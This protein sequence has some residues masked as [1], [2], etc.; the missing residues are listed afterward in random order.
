MNI[1]SV[2][3]QIS[4]QV[5]HGRPVAARP[6]ERVA[7]RELMIEFDPEP[8]PEVAAAFS[9]FCRVTDTRARLGSYNVHA[10]TEDN[11]TRAQ[12]T[13]TVNV[14]DVARVGRAVAD[15]VV[16]ASVQAF[17]AAVAS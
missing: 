4:D 11:T 8:Y 10:V 6:A 1:N 5:A 13:V 3:K 12:V 17:A 2:A 16:A 15:D 7:A 14:S 9:E